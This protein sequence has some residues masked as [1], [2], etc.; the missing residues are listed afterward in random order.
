[1]KKSVLAVF[2][3]LGFGMS[4][5]AEEI[6]V[7]AWNVETFHFFGTCAEIGGN[8]RCV[9][10]TSAGSSA[11]VAAVALRDDFHG[12]DVI[13][14]SEVVGREEA[15]TFA[16]IAD[17]DEN[18][19][20][21][22][23][24]GDS[25]RNLRVAMIFASERLDLLQSAE[26][27]FA[28]TTGGSRK[29]LAAKFRTKA[30]STE[31]WVVAVH[32]TRGQTRSDGSGSGDIRNDAQSEELREW[33]EAQSEPVIAL[34][35]FNYDINFVDGHQRIG[36]TT[37]TE[38]NGPKW[39]EPDVALDTNWAGE[40]SDEYPNSILDFVFLSQMGSDWK[41]RSL[42]YRR[43]GDFPDTWRTADH[44]PVVAFFET[45]PASA[46]SVDPAERLPKLVQADEITLNRSAGP[47]DTIS[48]SAADSVMEKL[49]AADQAE[50]QEQGEEERAIEAARGLLIERSIAPTLQSRDIST[51]AVIDAL[52][53]MVSERMAIRQRD[54]LR[55]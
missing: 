16:V 51:D 3:S 5:T 26:L 23:L 48:M 30:D 35:D 22:H 45:D 53:R 2:L 6:S 7:A 54:R 32:L 33:M 19:G 11:A 55:E 50:L 13:A 17:E 42:I 24:V 9:E 39:I 4:A 18:L 49:A 10:R 31:F 8:G 21:R 34:G 28:S 40:T 12:F 37:F 14:F 44:R 27:D 20:Y 52:A 46:L 38:N 1:M 47:T 25:G 41:S 29:P 15:E 43:A 36:F